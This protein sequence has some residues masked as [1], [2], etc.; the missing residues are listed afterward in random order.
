MQIKKVVFF[1]KPGERDRLNELAAKYTSESGLAVQIER[2]FNLPFNEA[3]TV[4]KIWLNV[5]KK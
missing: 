2:E 5:I 4:S 3:M 1:D